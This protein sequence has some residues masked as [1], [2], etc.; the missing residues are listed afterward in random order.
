[1]TEGTSRGDRSDLDLPKAQQDL[2]RALYAVGKPLVVVLINGS[3]ISVN[4]CDEHAR[5]I[6]EA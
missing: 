5:A 1:M 4:W 2:L 3:A 6:L